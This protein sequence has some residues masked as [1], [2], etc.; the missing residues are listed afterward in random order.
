[1]R[2]KTLLLLSVCACLFSQSGGMPTKEDLCGLVVDMVVKDE[3][4]DCFTQAGN[5][6]VNPEGVR[7][8]VATYLPPTVANCAVPHPEQRL[9]VSV[10]ERIQQKPPSQHHN[11]TNANLLPN[12]LN[13]R[14]RDVSRYLRKE[15][16]FTEQAGKMVKNV[17]MANLIR[18]GGPAL[19]NLEAQESILEIPEVQRLVETYAAGCFDRS[20]SQVRALNSEDEE[21]EEEEDAVKAFIRQMEYK[22]LEDD[23]NEEEEVKNGGA[24]DLIRILQND[25]FFYPIPQ[26]WMKPLLTVYKSEMSVWY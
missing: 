18:D 23:L 21:E 20:N 8:C 22:M 13:R 9:L 16:R 1:M 5:I 17:V 4:L 15:M 26:W 25:E 2:G 3:C 10:M 14:L 24:M 7:S 19:L 12:C 11:H 6:T